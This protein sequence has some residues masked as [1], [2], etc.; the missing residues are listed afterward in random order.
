M[1][2]SVSE[3]AGVGRSETVGER[4]GR[5]DGIVVGSLVVGN[6]EGD[7]EGGEVGGTVGENVGLVEGLLLAFIEV[8]RFEG[9]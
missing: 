6:F 5:V 1:M 2:I 8:G 4:V 9:D 3:N 7:N